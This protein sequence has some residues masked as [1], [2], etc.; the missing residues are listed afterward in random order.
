M[1]EKL[2][3]HTFDFD[4]TIAGLRSDFG[5][6]EAADALEDVKN[7]Y[8]GVLYFC[9]QNLYALG[10]LVNNTSDT[11]LEAWLEAGKGKHK[12]ESIETL[13]IFR[14]NLLPESNFEKLTERLKDFY[15]ELAPLEEDDDMRELKKKLVLTMFSTNF[16]LFF[17]GG[18]EAYAEAQAWL[19]DRE[20][21]DIKL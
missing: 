8:R 5:K 13:T 10:R 20:F 14:T 21:G 12:K 16:T 15:L 7:V 1:S 19:M 3:I 17:E 2:K 9:I 4:K 18:E 6:V 11:E